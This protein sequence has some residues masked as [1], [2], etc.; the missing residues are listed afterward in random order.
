[1]LLIPGVYYGWSNNLDYLR[2]WHEQMVAPYAAGIVMSEHKNQSLPGLLHR[3]LSDEPSFSEY[4]G[5]RK[6]VLEQHNF[7][8]WNHAT[9]QAIGI[10]CMILF[11]GLAIWSCRTST[12]IRPRLATAG[13]VQRRDPRHAPLL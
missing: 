3:M 4:E 8:S 10:G 11:A 9:V 1:M 12:E 7:G 5:E 13:G 6:I 2:G